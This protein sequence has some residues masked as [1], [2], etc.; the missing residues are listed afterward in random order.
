MSRTPSSIAWSN[1][2]DAR[3]Q[4]RRY[5]EQRRDAGETELVLDKLDVDDVLRLVGARPGTAASKSEAGPTETWRD[6]L[7]ESGAAPET[8]V[9][10]TPR[11]A[12]PPAP[13]RPQV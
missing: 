12:P 1:C 7:R 3:E 5:L 2:V 11:V 6:V 8:P 13:S 4:L 10:A 9:A